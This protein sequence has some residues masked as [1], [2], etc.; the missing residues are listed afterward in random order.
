MSK[1]TLA[2]VKRPS[3]KI[4]LEMKTYDLNFLIFDVVQE[5][6]QGKKIGMVMEDDN[7]MCI[8]SYSD[9]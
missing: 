9:N 2:R 6:R 3:D 5:V 8:Y 1:K 7:T 4:K